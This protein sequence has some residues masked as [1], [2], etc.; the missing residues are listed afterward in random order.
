MLIRINRGRWLFPQLYIVLPCKQ[1]ISHDRLILPPDVVVV[2][3]V[4]EAPPAPLVVL[5]LVCIL[6]V[7]KLLISV[8]THTLP[9]LLTPPPL[10]LRR[11]LIAG[12]LLV[13]LV[14]FVAPLRPALAKRRCLSNEIC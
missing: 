7:R 2:W 4:S 11:G 9:A 8:S 6:Y 13:R 1:V 10:L 3:I 14:P 12:V 5:L